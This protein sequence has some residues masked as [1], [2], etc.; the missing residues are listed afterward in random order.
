[1][2]HVEKTLERATVNFSIYIFFLSLYNLLRKFTFKTL[3]S[4]I[5]DKLPCNELQ[6]CSS[7]NKK[8]THKTRQHCNMLSTNAVII[9]IRELAGAKLSYRCDS[10]RL[11]GNAWEKTL[12]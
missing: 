11:E 10:Q 4:K 12:C 2:R 6:R 9:C 1:M 7:R 5:F 8:Q 3:G